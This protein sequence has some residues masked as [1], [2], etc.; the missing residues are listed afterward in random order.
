VDER[1]RVRRVIAYAALGVATVLVAHLAGGEN[2]TQGGY[3]EHPALRLI[4]LMTWG[5]L[6]GAAIGWLAA[7]TTLRTTLPLGVATITAAVGF[8]APL[9]YRENVQ[10]SS[11][12]DA[13]E[14]AL[15][16]LGLVGA[17]VGWA[18]G[19]SIGLV[20]P[21]PAPRPSREEAMR[22]RGVALA[23]MLIGVLFAWWSWTDERSRHLRP[24]GPGAR[25]PWIMLAD[26]ALVAVTLLAVAG[27][28]R[29][30]EPADPDRTHR[31][32]GGIG[33]A[34]MGLGCLV[35]VAVV[36]TAPQGRTSSETPAQRRAN[37]RT[38]VSVSGAARRYMEERGEV[39]SD[40]P[41]L[42]PFGARQYPSTVIASVAALEDGVCVLVGADHDGVAV[43]PFVS[44]VVY[45]PR[46]H[47]VLSMSS[48]VGI[49]PACGGVL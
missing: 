11:L 20:L 28:R 32:A 38:L 14:Q 4:G 24:H 16:L 41:S 9:W 44:R 35:L 7:Q 47:G 36:A 26:A 48:G 45:L 13:N 31:I 40:L 1:G 15:L 29:H 43:E 8:I 27:I 3:V 39:P 12:L 18:I 49:I 6:V 33:R 25:I 23:A 22:T 10:G 37:D 30:D 19:A 34:G 21:N 2:G 5:A 46:T 42:L 17:G